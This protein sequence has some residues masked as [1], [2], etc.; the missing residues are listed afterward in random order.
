MCLIIFGHQADPDLPLVVAANRDEFFG[1][2]TRP[3]QFWGSDDPDL[4]VLAGK[5]LQAGG[6]WL[7]ISRNGRFAAVTNIRDP[8]LA[9]GKPR[10]RG[11]LTLEF[12]QSTQSA[13]DYGE[14]LRATFDQFAG[15]NL[16]ISDGDQ[17]YYINNFEAI[18]RKLEPGIYGV[19][20]GV[21]DNDWPKVLLGKEK[22]QKL[23]AKSSL[24]GTHDLIDMMHDREPAPDGE[25]PDTGIS[26][27][28]ESK[29]SSAFITGDNR[30]YGTLCSTALLQDKEGHI[31][32]S[33]QNYSASG[34]PG[35][36]PTFNFIRS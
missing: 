15:Y 35:E 10:S 28:L 21:L 20:N 25:L 17:F 11:E 31:R 13:A 36:N 26:K 29:L 14:S 18:C 33:E 12:L 9:E 3:A 6:T 1:R 2:P 8:S 30:G 34:E 23:M 32:F 24:L 5:D 19:S 7:G 22:L 4:E 27:E 16:L